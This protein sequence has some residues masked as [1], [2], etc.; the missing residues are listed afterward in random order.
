[1]K[2]FFISESFF[3]LAIILITYTNS[4]I[5]MIIKMSETIIIDDISSSNNLISYGK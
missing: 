5:K 2:S 3:C 1:M 4:N